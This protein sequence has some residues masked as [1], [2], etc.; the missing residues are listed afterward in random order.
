MRFP[1]SNINETENVAAEIARSVKPGDIINLYGNLG[2]GKTAFTRG[3]A[4]A[5]GYTGRVTSPTFTLMNIYAGGRLT[6]YHFDLYRL[7]GDADLESIGMDEYLDAGGVCVVEW[8]EIGATLLENATYHIEIRTDFERDMDYR[9][10][11]IREN[12]GH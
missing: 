2:A 7:T 1:C 9:E 6:V 3:L 5:L 12:I 8:P 10:I 4:R 11:M